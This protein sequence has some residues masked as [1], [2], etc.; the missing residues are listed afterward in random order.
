ME[1]RDIVQEAVIKA[2]PKKKKC[3]KVKW[4]SEEVLQIAE[5]RREQKE[6]EKRKVKR[7]KSWLK[8]QHLEN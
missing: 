2:I 5:Q 1:I 6:K 3:K 8:T 7:W 4:L